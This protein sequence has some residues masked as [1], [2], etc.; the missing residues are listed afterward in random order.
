MTRARRA[1]VYAG[2]AGAGLALCAAAFAQAGADAAGAACAGFEG[3]GIAATAI[4]L[5]TGGAA[6]QSARMVPARGEGSAAIGEYCKLVVAILPVDPQSPRIHFQ[7]NLPT[8]WNGKA[9]MF[10]G[11]GFNGTI[12]DPAGNI[13]HWAPDSPAPLARGYA[14]FNSDSGHQAAGRYTGLHASLDGSFGLND[15]ALDNFAGDFIKKTR[16]AAVHLIRLR[17]GA[18]PARL[19][20]AGG[21]AG[22]REALRAVTSW[23][24]DFDGA[25]AWYPGWNTVAQTLQYG[26]ITRA[27]A[28]PGAWPSPGKRRLLY[29]AVMEACDAK[30]GARDGIIANPAACRYSPAALRCPGG[31]DRGDGCLSDA[32]LRAFD[33]YASP[34]VLTY[35]L[36]G[37][38]TQ[39]PGFNV[40]AGVDTA[41]G[42]PIAS[43]LALNSEPP[44]HPAS[45]NMPYFSQYWDMWMRYFVAGDATLNPLSV[46]PRNP[47]IY[48]KR[49]AWLSGVQDVHQFDL[50]AF[51]NRGG[52]LL[53]AHGTAD[54]MA[55]PRASAD[56]YRRLVAAMGTPA[57]K[58]FVRYYEIPGFGH[59]FGTAFTA[60]WD[61]LSALEQWVEQ[62]AAPSGQVVVDI[63]AATR[64]RTRPL[65][66]FPA[67]PKYEGAGDVNAAASFRC[68]TD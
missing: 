3:K 20:I 40:Y 30:D 15:E 57:V 33:T 4:G 26:R 42:N 55:S 65:C 9:L 51:R 31:A 64:G 17:Y 46:D 19:Y 45:L 62:G 53:I 49:I 60:A 14:T 6:V 27:L 44:V 10:G 7:L 56:Y 11:G 13:P 50:T 25:I 67:W 39:Y 24:R 21:S 63:N 2:A 52:K 32:Q 61:S 23:P 48:Q 34:L 35:P 37:G 66:E 38:D 59:V 68:V 8:A 22:G 41:G 58:S 36:A 5:P 47:G 16:D 54:S 18:D 12:R 1:A 43:L 28:A 29:E